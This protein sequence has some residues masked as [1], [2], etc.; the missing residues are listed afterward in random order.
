ML[1]SALAVGQLPKKLFNLHK[2][3]KEATPPKKSTTIMVL[4]CVNSKQ[5][6]SPR[7]PRD[8]QQPEQLNEIALS[9]VLRTKDRF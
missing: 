3:R 4:R 5:D 8:G 7:T 9:L 1:G 2:K 6:D